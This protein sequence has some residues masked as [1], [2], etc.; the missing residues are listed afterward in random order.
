MQE[1]KIQNQKPENATPKTKTTINS[2][3]GNTSTSTQYGN[4]TSVIFSTAITLMKECVL[5]VQVYQFISITVNDQFIYQVSGHF[6]LKADES[7]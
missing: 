7:Q 1:L 2:S 5:L 6:S 3:L 4:G